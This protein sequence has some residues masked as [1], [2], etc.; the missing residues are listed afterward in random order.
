[1]CYQFQTI[2]TRPNPIYRAKNLSKKYGYQIY[3]NRED[4]NHMET[5]KINNAVGMVLLAIEIVKT[6]LITETGI[7]RHDVTITVAVLHLKCDI[8][9]GEA[10]FKEQRLKVS[11]KFSERILPMLIQSDHV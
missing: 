11:K 8:Y 4:L 7:G 6:K 5:H 9:I 2:I 10:F 3:L 1:M